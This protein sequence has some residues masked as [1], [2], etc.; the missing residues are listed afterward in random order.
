MPVMPPANLPPE[1]TP[2]GREMQNRL[3]ASESALANTQ[4]TLNNLQRTVDALAGRV[5]QL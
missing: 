1:S 3:E 5:S 2:W 4:Q